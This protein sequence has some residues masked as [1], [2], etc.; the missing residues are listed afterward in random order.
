MTGSFVGR[1]N[2]SI[3][4]VKVLN[5]K[6]LTIGKKLPSFPHKDR[7]L[8]CQSQRWEAS[9]CYHCASVAP[10]SALHM[11]LY[12]LAESSSFIAVRENFQFRK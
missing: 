8:N 6:L 12:S 10:I 1:R 9:V 2:H 4:L 7:G 11:M 5:C 3:Q